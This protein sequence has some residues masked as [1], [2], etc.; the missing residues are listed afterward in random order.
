MR[1]ETNDNANDVSDDEWAGTV[2][3]S[4][5]NPRNRSVRYAHDIDGFDEIS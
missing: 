3:F 1:E 4:I 2:L 5:E